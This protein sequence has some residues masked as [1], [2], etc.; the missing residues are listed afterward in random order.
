MGLEM[1]C[2]KAPG[3]QNRVRTGPLRTENWQDKSAGYQSMVENHIPSWVGE[4]HS[5]EKVYLQAI[6]CCRRVKKK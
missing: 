2:R 6:T 1:S 5:L 3:L 4:V